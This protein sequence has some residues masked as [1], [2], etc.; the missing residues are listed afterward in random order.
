LVSV[1]TGYWDPLDRCL[2]RTHLQYSEGRIREE[3]MKI[4]LYVWLGDRTIR[5]EY[6]Y[7]GNPDTRASVCDL[8]GIDPAKIKNIPPAA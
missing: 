1:L 8:L 4:D 2:D 3:K 7:F 5:S 6:L